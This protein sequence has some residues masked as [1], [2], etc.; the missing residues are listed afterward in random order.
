MR[1]SLQ[2]NTWAVQC[3]VQTF[4]CESPSLAI[5]ASF[6]II[7]SLTSQYRQYRSSTATLP[8]TYHRESIYVNL[9][10]QALKAGELMTTGWYAPSKGKY[11]DLEGGEGGP[12]G[13]TGRLDQ[14]G[15]RKGL[16]I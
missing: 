1:E 15:V 5:S 6:Y 11:A 12:C 2:K 8:V 4:R 14:L 16:W 3:L 7:L 13:E 9:L 10:P